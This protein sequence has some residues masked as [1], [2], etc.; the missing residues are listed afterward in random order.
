LPTHKVVLVEGN[1][2]SLSSSPWCELKELFDAR[3]Y[4]DCPSEVA[5][6]RVISRHLSTGNTV[7]DATRRADEN[8]VPNGALVQSE[9]LGNAWATRIV[10]SK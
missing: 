1:Y 3:W 9:T 4:V 7:E 2:L 6:A 5:R 10:Q 8:D